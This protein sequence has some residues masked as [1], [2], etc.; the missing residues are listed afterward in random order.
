ME[1]DAKNRAHVVEFFQKVQ[2]EQITMD[3]KI[4]GLGCGSY[5]T[6][7]WAGNDLYVSGNNERGQLG[8][9]DITNRHEFVC[10]ILPENIQIKQVSC[11]SYHTAI[12][13]NDYKLYVTGSNDFGELGIGQEASSLRSISVFTMVPLNVDII[14]VACGSSHMIVL[15][16]T[17]LAY[18]CGSNSH[19]QLGISNNKSQTS[20][21]RAQIFDEKITDIYCG[22]SHSMFITESNELYVAGNNS[23]GQLGQEAKQDYISPVI[24]SNYFTDHSIKFIACEHSNGTVLVTKKHEIFVVGDN[25]NGQ[26]GLGEDK[27]ILNIITKIRE[28]MLSSCKVLSISSGGNH[29]ILVVANIL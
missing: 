24:L 26:L 18:A 28:K 6:V 21:Q 13:A 1:N 4:L 9:G 23:Y 7:I 8:L 15:T 5:H 22:S 20:F 29:T 19:G 10:V 27:K 17:N 11:G 12:L 14:K 3:K 2:T 25:T 16:L